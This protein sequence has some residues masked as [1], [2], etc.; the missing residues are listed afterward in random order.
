MLIGLRMSWDEPYSS[1]AD[2]LRLTPAESVEVL[3][4]WSRLCLSWQV[5]GWGG[6]Y[7]RCGAVLCP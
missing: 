7:V 6:M 5:G 4:A 2:Q 1:L 3:E